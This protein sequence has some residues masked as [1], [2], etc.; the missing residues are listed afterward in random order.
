MQLEGAIPQANTEEYEEET[1]LLILNSIAASLTSKRKDVMAARAACGIENEWI[2]DDEF[3]QG[4]DDANRHEFVNTPAKPTESGAS[5][6]PAKVTGSTVFPNITGPAC[7]AFAARV[8]DVLLPSSGEKNF[9][10]EATEIPEMAGSQP[11][12]GPDGQPLDQVAAK[13]ADADARATKAEARVWDWLSECQYDGEVRKVIDDAARLGT[14]V[15]KGPVPVN[16]RSTVWKEGEDGV[17]ALVVVDEIKPASIRIDPWN[18]YPDYPACGENIH[19]GSFCWEYDQIGEKKLQELKGLPGYID[20][21]IDLCIDEGPLKNGDSSSSVNPNRRDS[22]TLFDIW[23]Y[24]GSV[25]AEELRAAGCDCGEKGQYPAIMTMVN[26]RVIRAALNPLDNGE[27]PYDLMPV[28]RRTG[29]PWGQGIARQIRTPQRIVTHNLRQLNNNAGLAG[30]PQ[31]TVRRG[32]RPENGLWEI[33]PLK[34]WVEEDSGMDGGSAQAPITATV[35]PMMQA[36]LMNN[37]QLGMKMSEDVTGLPALMQGQQ[38]SAPDTVGG[39][40]ILNNNANSV[41]RRVARLFD[42]YLT[43]PHIRR[44]YRWLME[45]GKDDSEKGDFQ[46]VAKG[47]TALVERDIQSQEMVNVLGLCLNPAYGKNPAKAMDEYLKSRRFNPSDFDYTEDEKKAMA[48]KQPPEDPR[49]TAAKIMQ[50]GAMGREQAKSKTAEDKLMAEAQFEKARMEF[51]AQQAEKD[52][53][54]E[55]ML[56]EVDA[57]LSREDLASDEKIAL[58]REKVLL[59]KVALQLKVQERMSNQSLAHQRDTTVAGHMVDLHKTKQVAQA[60]VEPQGRAPNGQGFTR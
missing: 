10:I 24:Y 56:A 15:L 51:E 34:L 28:K 9:A 48:E 43:E 8:G 30:G 41:L 29:M 16:R 58:E 3:Y 1:R 31:L 26:D 52:R 60:A 40:K 25:K 21:Q 4:Y 27:F 44:Y 7:D 57:K 39:M 33:V 35:I 22:K 6:T 2:G 32:I 50:E 37:I 19:N 11:Q 14:G 55:A 49:V 20:S 59:A 18:L 45:F 13:K 46:I 53:M 5:S 17:S 47:S 42:T 12:M 36:E 54:F 38:G 23:Y